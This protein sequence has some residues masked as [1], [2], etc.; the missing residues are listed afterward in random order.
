VLPAAA[1][2]GPPR[3]YAGQMTSPSPSS[4]SSAELAIEGMHCDACVALIEESLAE[5]A[6]V[7]SAS[8]DLGAALATVAFDPAQLGVEEIRATIAD[9]GYSATPV[10]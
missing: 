9:A 8:V 5:Q 2:P 4:P 6:G 7:I 10:S 3:N 1:R